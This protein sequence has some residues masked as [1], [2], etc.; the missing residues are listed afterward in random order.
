MRSRQSNQLPFLVAKNGLSIT[1][2]RG[3]YHPGTARE[4]PEVKKQAFL[5][6]VSP[7]KFSVA[8]KLTP[9]LLRHHYQNLSHH[10][11]RM[12]PSRQWHGQGDLGY[13]IMMRR[14]QDSMSVCRH[15]DTSRCY[16]RVTL[17]HLEER[18]IHRHGDSVMVHVRAP[19]GKTRFL[20]GRSCA[21]VQR[22]LS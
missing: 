5:G 1:W 22:V 15:L 17:S 4:F 10:V 13:Q 7:G 12:T 6:V 14:A 9:P 11:S 16:N 3:V 18:L 20:P 2:T 19:S 8:G 21:R